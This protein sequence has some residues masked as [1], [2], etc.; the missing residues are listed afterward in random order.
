MTRALRMTQPT[1]SEHV[2]VLAAAGIVR[3]VRKRGRTVYAV[4]PR[5]VERLLE[6]ARAT[7]V[8]WA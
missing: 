3:Q 8:R 2:R 5:S 7:V 6:D 4:S 1:V